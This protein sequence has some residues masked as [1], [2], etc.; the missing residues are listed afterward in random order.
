MSQL[1]ARPP[2]SSQKPSCFLQIAL[3]IAINITFTYESSSPLKPGTFVEVPFRQSTAMG[4]VWLSSSLK[5]KPSFKV[6]K[7]I[8]AYPFPPLSPS[9]ISFIDWV[10]KYTL[11]PLGNVLKL[12]LSVRFTEKQLSYV[13]TPQKKEEIHHL[14]L[15]PCQNKAWNSISPLISQKKFKPILLKGVTG[16]GKTAVYFKAIEKIIEQKKTCLV[17]QPE[18]NLTLD[19]VQRFEKYF[20]FSPLVWH[21]NLTPKK[22][23]ETW[24][25]ILHGQARV[26]IGARSALFL[27]FPELDL[28]VVDEEHDTGYKQED[29]VLYNA[30][31][32]AVV[33]AKRED[34][35]IILVS[36]TP[37]LETQVNVQKGRYNGIYINQ[38]YGNS[39]MPAVQLIDMKNKGS[40]LKFLK[41][42]YKGTPYLA[43]S[44]RKEIEKTLLRKEQVLVFLNRRGYAPL[45]MCRSCG[46]R[47]QCPNCTAWLIEHRAKSSLAC[48]HCGYTRVYPK[49]CPSCKKE[50]T[51]A[52]CGP[53]VER[54]EEEISCLFPK[55]NTVLMTSDTLA[56]QK[57]IAKK[58]QDIYDG[59]FDIIIGTQVM[60]KGHT[61]PN[62]T[63]TVVV[64]ADLGLST[65]DIR[66]SEK[67]F[68]LLQQ[69]GGRS[70]RTK[71][72][73][74]VFLQTFDPQHPVMKT[75]QSYDDESFYSLEQRKREQANLPPFGNMASITVSSSKEED[76]K[77][78]CRQLF[79]CI[80]PHENKI[81]ILGPAPASLAK[82]K[83][84]Y[85]WHFL[86]QTPKN[87]SRQ[88]FL[89]QWISKVSPPQNTK[90]SIDIDPQ[91]FL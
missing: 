72:P 24:L 87:F 65:I 3:P 55:A 73:G 47:L 63:L 33:K 28:I 14:E 37:S 70:G 4:V 1:Q 8:K 26:V 69:V 61:F 27:P 22:R 32:M 66:A 51:L 36:A 10:A 44:T 80:P 78:V 2:G 9:F 21:S 75:L 35:P 17:L 77:K 91:N 86:I 46:E 34:C 82:R 49:E 39:Q 31:D 53:G 45:T 16:S 18:I 40:A 59:K 57:D 58:F 52:P 67:T 56:N 76:A 88:N 60:A 12:S 43:L 74:K 20:G 6:R 71:K 90:I 48:H 50:E 62:L 13:P 15:S 81:K 30:R 23:R 11:A 84:Q 68:Q 7:I 29:Q 42:K 5:E 19:W 54:I 41:E 25:Q 38:R 85:R 64:D 83:R 79:S 89:L